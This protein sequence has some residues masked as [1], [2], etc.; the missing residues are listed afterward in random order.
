[1]QERIGFS[2]LSFVNTLQFN[3]TPAIALSAAVTSSARFPF[4]TPSS[5]IETAQSAE[6]RLFAHLKYMQLLDWRHGG[7]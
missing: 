6:N 1:M 5:L 3:K 7:Q 4:I 2:Q